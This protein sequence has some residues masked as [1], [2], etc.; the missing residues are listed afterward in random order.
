[1]RLINEGRWETTALFH[2]CGWIV[3]VADGKRV[4]LSA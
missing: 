3:A 4:I 1:L 2:V